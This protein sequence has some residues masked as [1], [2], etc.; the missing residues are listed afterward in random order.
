MTNPLVHAYNVTNAT[1]GWFTSSSASTTSNNIVYT[2]EFQQEPKPE[3]PLDW[4]FG[5][6]DAVCELGYLS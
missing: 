1:D 3:D 2:S 5:K 6:V 4:L